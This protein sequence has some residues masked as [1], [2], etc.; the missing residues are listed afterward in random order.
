MVDGRCLCPSGSQLKN[1][2]CQACSG[3]DRYVPLHNAGGVAQMPSC[4]PCPLGT[5]ASADHLS[6]V[7]R[8]NNAAGEVLD[9]ATGKC[10]ACPA[11]HKVVYV[12]GSLG[13]CEACEYGQ[14][15]S[16]DRKSCVPA[17]APGQVLGL[18]VFGKDPMAD[19]NAY[20]CQACPANTY[21]SYEEADSS[22]GTCLPCAAGTFAKAGATQCLP[23]NCGPSSY[24][25]PND[26]HACKSCPPT[27][28]YIPAAKKMVTVP[29]SQAGGQASAQFVPGH[30]GCGENQKLVGAICVCPA[31]AI[32]PGGSL[33]KCTCPKGA[34]LDMATFT[35]GCPEGAA[36][37]K[38]TGNDR[39]CVCA[40]GSRLENGKCVLPGVQLHVNPKDCSALGP[41]Y[42]NDPKNVAACV[43]CAAGRIANAER[44]ACV[45]P[46]GPVKPA[47]APPVG[48]APKPSLHCPPGT[49]PNASES[50][51]IRPPDLRRV[52]PPPASMGPPERPAR[53]DVPATRN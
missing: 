41:S 39:Q 50:A 5:K 31:G 23:L 43:L 7:N 22:K 11:N 48:R 34:T 53:P 52:I 32:N 38:A 1:D 46:P 44:S 25:D 3:N 17:C 4:Q 26:P 36:Y 14:T 24:Q 33:A 19:P 45:S 42:I 30:C 28:I 10:V 51:C 21:A 18:L 9:V 40:K 2:A 37:D 27:Q 12:S 8:C 13:H 29:G 20:Q 35:C 49:V 15:A 16:A 6:C 47:I